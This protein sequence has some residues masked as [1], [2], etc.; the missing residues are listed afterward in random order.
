MV[1]EPEKN[2]SDC[3]V[4][5]AK[6][7][8]TQ[9]PKSIGCFYCGTKK[10]SSVSCSDHHFVCDSCHTKEALEIINDVCLSTSETDM[11]ELLRKIRSHP[12]FPVHGPEHH[13]LVPGIILT[14]YRNSG[15]DITIEKIKT[16]IDRGSKIPGGYC[17]YI[18]ACGAAMGVGIAYAIIFESTPLKPKQRRDSLKIT[19]EV[20]DAIAQNKAARCCQRES[21]TALLTAARLSERYLDIKLKMNEGFNCSQSQLNNECIKAACPFWGEEE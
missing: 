8:Y 12:K 7:V 21:A 5:G 3:M 2:T 4:C 6:L 19:S 15:G 17:G 1:S 13:A 9:E 14:A 10:T 18:G 16:G 20:L 11:A